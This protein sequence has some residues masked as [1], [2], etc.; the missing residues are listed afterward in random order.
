[1]LFRGAIEGFFLRK[2]IKPAVA[3][4]VSAIIFGVIH[5]NPAQI[6]FAFILGLIFGWM[7]YRT[8][9][10]LPS[11]VGHVLNNTVSVSVM[12]T[13]PIE[14]MSKTTAESIGMTATWFLLIACIAIAIL[15]FVYLRKTLP[16]SPFDVNGND[17]VN[18]NENGNE[19]IIIEN[20]N[21]N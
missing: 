16:S 9:S 6:F 3:I 17:N 5:A 20:N 13:S 4:V 10:I 19:N 1:M 2:G 15:S 11:V 12:A 7:Y 8:G 18:E 21:L 14:D